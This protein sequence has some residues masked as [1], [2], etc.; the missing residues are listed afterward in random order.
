MSAD[1]VES[2]RL[3]QVQHIGTHG[4]AVELKLTTVFE[5]PTLELPVGP[6]IVDF[7]GHLDES[8]ASGE[9]FIE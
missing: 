2:L 8:L 5:T 4:F 1:G 3:R 9:K 7:G 6:F